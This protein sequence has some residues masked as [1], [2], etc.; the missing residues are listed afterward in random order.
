MRCTRL[1]DFWNYNTLRVEGPA[2][3]LEAAAIVAAADRRLG[4]LAHRQVEVE[5]DATGRRLRPEFDALGWATERNVWMRLAG[6]A[7]AG[8]DF[9]EEPYAATLPL[10]LEWSRS[11]PWIQ[12]E[13]TVR[14]FT[15]SED[16][17]AAI[18]GLRALLAHDAAGA[19]IG[20]A[21]F[22]AR[23]D[24]AEI[25]SAYV[26]PAHRGGGL[27][28]LVAAAARMT[29]A[30]DSFIVAD[31]EDAPKRLYLRLGFEPVWTQH[32]FTKRPG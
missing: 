24:G 14:R 5:D 13:E 10:R 12:D 21:V 9:D 32:V 4:D 31:D 8:P 30:V 20:Y 7:P 6:A 15:R 16:M 27:G 3:A 29:A 26:Q 2:P 1:P 19:P 28:A 18:R 11:L 17:V 22:A 23:G 25:D